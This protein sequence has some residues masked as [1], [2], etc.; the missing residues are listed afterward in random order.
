MK[1]GTLDD[2][3]RDGQLIVVSR[4]LQRAH[5]ATDIAPRI[6]RAATCRP[7]RHTQCWQGPTRLRLRS[8]AMPCAATKG[9]PMG[10]W[11]VLCEPC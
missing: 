9:L 10:R 4:D 1:L 3:T 5:L 2:G 11:F 8:A 6:S 7:L